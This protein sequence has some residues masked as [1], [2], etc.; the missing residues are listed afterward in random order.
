MEFPDPHVWFVFPGQRLGASIT[1]PVHF[2]DDQR[3]SFHD[4]CEWRDKYYWAKI[5]WEISQATIFFGWEMAQHSLTAPTVISQQALTHII[6]FLTKEFSSWQV[7]LPSFRT[8]FIPVFLNCWLAKH[9]LENMIVSNTLS[10]YLVFQCYHLN[11]CVMLFCWHAIPPLPSNF[12]P[13][14]LS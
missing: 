3:H 9:A 14:A 7:I 1:C 13:P 5:T 2:G 6:P 8:L 12:S 11:S 4:H 10:P